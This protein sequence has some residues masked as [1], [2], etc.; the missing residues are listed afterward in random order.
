MLS[1]DLKK[2]FPGL[3]KSWHAPGLISL[4]LMPSVI[5]TVKLVAKFS[6]H[7]IQNSLYKFVN[8]KRKCSSYPSSLKFEYFSANTDQGIAVLLGNFFKW[9]THLRFSQISLTLS[10]VTVKPYILSRI[11]ESS[12]LLYL[13]RVKPVHFPAPDGVRLCAEVF[14]RDLV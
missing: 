7:C 13:Q 9:L 12:P 10:H 4:C 11:C 6:L 1:F 5:K 14:Y 3:A 8:E 2:N